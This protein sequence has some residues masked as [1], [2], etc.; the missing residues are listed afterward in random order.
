MISSAAGCQAEVGAAMAMGAAGA[1]EMRG[2]TPEEALNA[3]A[4]VLKSYLG[5][6]CDPLGGLVAVPCIKRNALGCTSALAAS[7]LSMAG[8]VSY[9][10]FDEVVEALWR[11]GQLMSPKIKET[12]LGGLAVTP[13]G[14][15]IR[16]SLGLPDIKEEFLPVSHKPGRQEQQKA[17]RSLVGLKPMK[18]TMIKW[19][20]SS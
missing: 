13:T 14:L 17:G 1:T 3:S 6:A 19:G 20:K 18:G 11:I 12:A 15:K 5:V 2:G 8:V 16:K 7:D 4:L 9:V 10:P